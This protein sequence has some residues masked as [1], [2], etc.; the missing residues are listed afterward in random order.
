MRVLV[1]GGGEVGQNVARVLSGERHD[2]TL[3]DQDAARVEALQ[4]EIDALVLA[5]NGASPRF[6]RDV[7]AGEADLLVA[8]TQRDETNVIA[9][10]AGHQLG[11]HQTIARVR[12]PDYF[13][14]GDSFARDELGI[15]FLINPERATAEDLAEAILLPGAVHVEYFAEDRVAVAES[16]LTERSPLLG[17]S[18]AERRRVRPHSIIGIIREGQAVPCEPGHRPRVADHVLVAAAR[19]DIRPVVAD[20]AGHAERVHE[21]VVFGGG[22]IGLHLAR[23]LQES[24]EVAVTVMERDRERARYI[25]ERLPGTTVLHEEGVGREVLLSQGVDRAGAFVACAGDD[26]ANLL[27]ALHAKKLGAGICMAVV[28]REEFIPLVDAL[29]IDTAVSPRLVTSEAILR[30]VRGENVRAMYL[31]LGGAEVLEVQADTG[32][33]AEGRTVEQTDSMARTHV[34]AIVRDGRVILPEK[35]RETVR[36]SDRLVVFNARPGVA[37]VE[38]AFTAP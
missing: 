34:A 14:P 29:G 2:V 21:A 17:L 12:D 20:L 4:G 11:A 15:D 30:A 35:G 37:D 7:S 26:R 33:R 5:G 31:L 28:S 10:L 1:I 32:C 13:G 38:R 22:R 19:E 3:I 24:D 16:I 6:L 8:V 23:R 27:A 36:G 18:L 9:A 25:A